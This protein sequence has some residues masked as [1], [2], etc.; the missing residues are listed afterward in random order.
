MGQ[1]GIDVDMVIDAKTKD[2]CD[3]LEPSEND[4]EEVKEE[5]K[6]KIQEFK[7]KIKEATQ[8]FIQQK[9]DEAEALYKSIVTTCENA[10]KSATTWSVQ[11]PAMAVPDPMAPKAGAASLVALKN[12][13]SM[14]KAQVEEANSKLTS[15]NTLVQG[16]GIPIPA[17]IYTATTLINQA[18]SLLGV[19]PI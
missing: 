19:I 4:S 15:L 8:E 5:K 6:K 10:I 1:L 14:A 12:S 3:S 11:V 16:F 2:Y 18:T 13:V 9:I 7:E 17:P